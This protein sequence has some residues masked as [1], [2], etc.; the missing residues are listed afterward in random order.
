M[1]NE[2]GHPSNNGGCTINY[3]HSV[4]QIL[5]C[6]RCYNKC[7]HP[8]SATR[9]QTQAALAH[10]RRQTNAPRCKDLKPFQALSDTKCPK[11]ELNKF[12]I[13]YYGQTLAFQTQYHLTHAAIKQSYTS[14][15]WRRLT[16]TDSVPLSWAER[17]ERRHR[18]TLPSTHTQVLLTPTPHEPFTQ[19]IQWE[20]CDIGL[21]TVSDGVI[22]YAGGTFVFVKQMTR[23][24]LLTLI[25]LWVNQLRPSLTTVVDLTA[26]MYRRNMIRSCW[27]L[28]VQHCSTLLL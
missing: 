24:M 10:S 7:A 12:G 4:I 8:A 13:S 9:T 18:V 5:A 25:Y 19:T 15:L 20:H 27:L 1:S 14:E 16:E 28:N 17:I 6:R 11:L 3:N 22:A 26:N 21:K 2:N 23:L